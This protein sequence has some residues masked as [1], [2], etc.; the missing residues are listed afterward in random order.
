MN[1]RWLR[2]VAL[3]G[4]SVALVTCGKSSSPTEPSCPNIAGSWSGSYTNSCGGHAAGVVGITQQGCSFTFVGMP[5]ISTGT[6]N[7]NVGTFSGSQPAPCANN[8]SG[9]FTVNG[10]MIT[11][12]LT[13]TATSTGSGCCPLGP[14]TGAF[15]LTR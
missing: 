12:S 11:G 3:L 13:G 9:T 4:V 2:L 5:P 1:A 14:F 10:N 8:G 15:T 7:G 6:L